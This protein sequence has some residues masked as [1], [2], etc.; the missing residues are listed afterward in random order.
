[1]RTRAGEREGREGGRSEKG[2][3][4]GIREKRK[5]EEKHNMEKDRKK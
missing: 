3:E 4:I 2:K 1:M 5:K